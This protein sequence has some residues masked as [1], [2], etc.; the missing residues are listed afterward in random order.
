MMLAKLQFMLRIQQPYALAHNVGAYFLPRKIVWYEIGTGISQGGNSKLMKQVDID[1]L[2]TLDSLVEKFTKDRTIRA[3][4]DLRLKLN[5]NSSVFSLV[6]KYP[7][8]FMKKYLYGKVLKN[9]DV[10]YSKDDY[11]VLLNRLNV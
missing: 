3:G 8:L 7:L 9:R 11:N 1:I 6:K 10:Q 5:E 4:R 2:K